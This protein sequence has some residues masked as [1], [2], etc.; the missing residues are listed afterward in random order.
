MS[1]NRLSIV[2]RS[3]HWVGH[4]R[5]LGLVVWNQDTT[6]LLLSGMFKC[7]IQGHFLFGTRDCDLLIYYDVF[8]W[9]KDTCYVIISPNTIGEPFS[10]TTLHSVLWLGFSAKESS[11]IP[12]SHIQKCLPFS[13]IYSSIFLKASQYVLWQIASLD[14]P[15]YSHQQPVFNSIFFLSQY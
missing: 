8:K 10:S 7:L 6:S 11:A 9:S 2:L 15:G 3:T 12:W 14:F 1:L 4:S 13:T 5:T